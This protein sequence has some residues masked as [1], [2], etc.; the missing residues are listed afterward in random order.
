MV[1]LSAAADAWWAWMAAMSIQICVFVVIITLLDRILARRSWVELSTAL[2]WL[3]MLKLLLPP[4]LSSPVSVAKWD[5]N[6]LLAAESLLTAGGSGLRLAFFC[7]WA[8]IVGF[9]LAVLAW[10]YRKHRTVHLRDAVPAGDDWR[11]VLRRA[12]SRLGLRRV[13]DVRLS[14]RA[15]GPFVLGLFHPVIILPARPF[16]KVTSAQ[17]EHV[18]LHE[19]A[20]VCRR[21][22]LR[23]LVCSIIHILYWFHPFIWW[24]HTRLAA[25]RE[26]ACDR[27]VVASLSGTHVEYRRTL[28]AMAR[29]MLPTSVTAGLPFLHRH[30]SLLARLQWLEHPVSQP[31]MVRR[32]GAGL[33][34]GMVL[35]CLVPLLSARSLPAFSQLEG[36]LQRRY[37]VLQRLAEEENRLAADNGQPP[38]WAAAD[39]KNSYPD[40]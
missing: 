10:K 29:A 15:D 34:C 7:T 8:T 9:L 31:G 22:P 24:A 4:T 36:C 20:H 17:W 40:G 16:A 12:S 14:D 26:I 33:V 38:R 27:S 2:W 39:R 28:L 3:V 6:R 25:L 37:W 5:T 11:P 19:M 1:W 35:A 30:S 13:P 23:A 18:L 32:W 21:D